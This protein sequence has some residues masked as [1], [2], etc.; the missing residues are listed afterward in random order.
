MAGLLRLAGAMDGVSR[1]FARIAAWLVLVSCLISA[2]N[3]TSRYLFSVSSNAWLEIQWQMFAGH[4]PARRARNVL[5]LNEHVRVDLLYGCAVAARQALDRRVRHRL[6][7]DPVHA[8]D[9]LLLLGV[10]PDQ[11]PERRAFVERRRACCSGRSK[12]LL[13]FGLVLRAAAGRRGAHQAH[14]RAARRRRGHDRRTT[15][16]R[17]Q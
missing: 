6:L 17:P 14:R 12:F 1:F 5:R 13:P 2:G 4:L 15:K 16:G 8:D 9:D 10:L 11:L 7:P 3:A